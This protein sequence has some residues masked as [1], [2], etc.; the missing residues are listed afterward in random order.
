MGMEPRGLFHDPR[1]AAIAAVGI[2]R[3][4]RRR[5]VDQERIRLRPTPGS[6]AGTRGVPAQAEEFIP[7]FLNG[8][9]RC[10]GPPRRRRCRCLSLADRPPCATK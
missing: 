5:P 10:R 2:D 1:T 6:K 7:P 8:G 4:H 9:N 3:R